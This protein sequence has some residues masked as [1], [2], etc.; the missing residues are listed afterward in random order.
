MQKDTLHK[1]VEALK[2]FAD[3]AGQ[4]S[5]LNGDAHRWI[6]LKPRNYPGYLEHAVGVADFRRASEALS[7]LSKGGG[8]GILEGIPESAIADGDDPSPAV[9]EGAA[10]LEALRPLIDAAN[11]PKPQP[12][13]EQSSRAAEAMACRADDD[14][15]LAW[16]GRVDAARA[17]LA[18]ALARAVQP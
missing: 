8:I 17:T 9:T 1:L 7:L 4:M 2:P 13:P 11:E 12:L 16:K 10:L 14:A 15:R 6:D 3:A 18:T 5:A